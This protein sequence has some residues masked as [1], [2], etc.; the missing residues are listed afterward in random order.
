MKSHNFLLRISTFVRGT[1]TSCDKNRSNCLNFYQ[2]FIL[3]NEC[4]I[5]YSMKNVKIYI[6]I[7]IKSAPTCFGLNNHHQRAWHLCFAKDI[8][9]KIVIDFFQATN[10]MHTSYIL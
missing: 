9:I 2:V 5:K 1:F 4:T 6:K 3:S 8:I 10:L 7:N